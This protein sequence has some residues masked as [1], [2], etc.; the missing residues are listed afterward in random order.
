MMRFVVKRLPVADLTFFFHFFRQQN[1]T[2]QKSITLNRR[3]FI[4]VIFPEVGR[5]ADATELELPVPVAIYGP[6][7]R[8]KPHLV[9]RKIVKEAK[10][11]RLNGEAVPDPDDEPTRYHGLGSDD[12]AVFGFEGENGFPTAVNSC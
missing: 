1:S 10:N 6:G 8:I 9:T 3:V 2:N 11:W 7:L 4:D 5:V 12:I